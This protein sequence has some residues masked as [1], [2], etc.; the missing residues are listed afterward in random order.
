MNQPTEDRIKKLEEEQRQLTECDNWKEPLH[1]EGLCLISYKV[2]R[3]CLQQYT[4][5]IL[6]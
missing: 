1:S 4:I 6:H 5:F 2:I 3:T